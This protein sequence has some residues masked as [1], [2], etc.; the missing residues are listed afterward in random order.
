V[1][2]DWR[3]GSG[4]RFTLD[5]P[6]TFAMVR[7]MIARIGGQRLGIATAYIERILRLD[8]RK[9][10]SA[11]GRTLVETDGEPIPVVSLARV[12]GP[13]LVE[14][15]AEG[16][17]PAVLCRVGERRVALAVDEL[18]GEEELV[19]RP[20]EGKG[21]VALPGLSGAAVLADGSLAL[22]VNTT[23]AVLAGL[24]G[25]AGVR[26]VAPE[27]KRVQRR[28]LVVDDSI[29]T[30]TLEQGVLESGGY[31]VMTAVDGVD[32]WRMLQE[33]GADLVVADVEMPRM[34]GFELCSTIRG[35]E[36]FRS[37]PVVL[38]TALE[39]P[40]HRARGLE[41]GADAYIGKSSFDQETLLDTL[42]QL[43]G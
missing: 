26:L 1:D 40:E 7:A 4:T 19:V 9:L 5:A 24:A 41:V 2:V 27:E 43:L 10:R 14:R 15:R 3:A 20:I 11:A 37:L 42:R 6:L 8:P 38:V 31:E 39:T 28:V 21:T 12:L 13:P 30:R 17:F 29:T 16:H 23:A 34:D 33:R 36:R 35:S 32:G 25:E 18:V 22:V